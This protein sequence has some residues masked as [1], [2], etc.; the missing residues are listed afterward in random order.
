MS[1]NTAQKNAL[2][3][4]NPAALAAGAGV[5]NLIDD[6]QTAVASGNL[7]IGSDAWDVDS[8]CLA[9]GHV[10]RDVDSDSG[11]TFGYFGGR[12][13]VPGTGIVTVA[14]GTIALS[15]SST[16]YVEVNSAGVVSK[17]TT[18]FTATSAPLFTVVTSGSGITSVTQSKTLMV[19]WPSAG[20]P[21]SALSTAA[22]TKG[23][24]IVA[25]TIS[26]T[27][28]ILVACPSYAAT[29]S[30]IALVVTTTVA[31]DD[32][33]YWTFSALN[34]GPSG[35]GTTALL[36]ASDLNTTKDTGGSGLTNYV[37]R[38]M[39]LHGTSANL[40]TAANDVLVFTATK[41]ASAANLV[42]AVLLVEFTNAG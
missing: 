29:V 9:G 23:R 5:G 1:L 30:R 21:G 26:A 40:N 17:N 37:A 41:T 34:K 19:A 38:A 33:N 18:G 13:L 35:S 28:D 39:T 32:T 20:L 22:K 11:L 31:A 7:G 14:A 16:N 42:N 3:S 12:V 4:G 8:I 24:Q 15:A 10:A 2:N 36:T 6:L 27:G 25:G